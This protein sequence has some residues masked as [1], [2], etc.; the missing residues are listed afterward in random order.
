MLLPRQRKPGDFL[1]NRSMAKVRALLF[2]LPV[3]IGWHNAAAEP[4]VT[5]VFVHT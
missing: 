3:A 2:Y 5:D 1:K 4:Q